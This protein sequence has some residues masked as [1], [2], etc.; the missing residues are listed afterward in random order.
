MTLAEKRQEFKNYLWDHAADAFQMQFDLRRNLSELEL[1]FLNNLQGWIVEPD[2]E[3]ALSRM[4]LGLTKSM[5]M[6]SLVLQI[7]GLTRNK[8]LTD[9]RASDAVK[10]KSIAIPSNFKRICSPSVWEVS[11]PYLLKRLR[12]VFGHINPKNKF[13]NDI[14]EALNQATWPSYIRQE[15]A[16]RSGHEAEYRI[17]T[18]LFSLHIPFA[19]AEKAENPLCRD[20][21]IDNI[22][23]DIVVPNP[24]NPSLV[25]KS[26]VHT[27]NIGRYGESKDH[28]EIKEA[29]TWLDKKYREA[30]KKPTLLAFIDGVGFHSNKAGL[31]GVLT[32]A[33]EF[34]QFKTIWKAA[35][36]AAKLSNVK[37]QIAL[38][39]EDRF[40]FEPFLSAWISRKEIFKRETI[41]SIAGWQSSGNA[42]IRLKDP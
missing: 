7:S 1:D 10:I 21:Q 9:L 6:I 19:P 40:A 37:L 4:L 22:S 23:F 36:I 30:T 27:A 28:L 18:L 16:K 34:C 11:G 35:L 41:G 24:K 3:R 13:R 17:A 20:V 8:I 29:R 32:H 12:S 26:T 38:S 42:L 5:D 31:D 14:F 33:D 39:K 2:D 15:R 25:I